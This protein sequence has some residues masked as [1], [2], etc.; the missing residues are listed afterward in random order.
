VPP[1]CT[2][3]GEPPVDYDPPD[4]PPPAAEPL[5]CCDAERAPHRLATQTG[6]FAATGACTATRGETFVPPACTPPGDPPLVWAPAEEAPPPPPE[7]PEPWPTEPPAQ[8]PATQT[9]ALAATGACTFA[10][11]AIL[12]PPACT[13]AGDPDADCAP[14]P[15]DEPAGAVELVL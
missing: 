7:R 1:A 12:V 8:L 2:P 14:A 13:L 10:C 3:R 9:G 4:A 11:G 6:A 15:P 5:V